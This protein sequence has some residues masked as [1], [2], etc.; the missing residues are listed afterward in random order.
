MAAFRFTRR[1]RQ[2]Q[3]LWR[4]TDDE[5]VTRLLDLL[6]ERDQELE[7]YSQQAQ[8]RSFRPVLGETW[9]ANVGGI[10]VA[11]GMVTVAAQWII[12]P[13]AGLPA[14]NYNFNVPVPTRS[15]GGGTARI[16]GYNI[17]GAQA[18]N[19]FVCF[20]EPNV[21]FVGATEVTGCVI[22]PHGVNG[23]LTSTNPFNWALH[24]FVQLTLV[25]TYPA[26]ET[27]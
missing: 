24:N 3:D 17:S 12:D 4:A 20:V 13:A 23:N 16:A 27:A 18:T 11:D 9:T 1:W 8:V 6:N 10:Q 25:V 2:L 15:G 21:T 5:S 19:S 7:Q 22:H 26:K 14:A